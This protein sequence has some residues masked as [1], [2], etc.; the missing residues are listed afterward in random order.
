MEC[1][2]VIQEHENLLYNGFETI[3]SP[4]KLPITN[5]VTI[6]AG[7]SHSLALSSDGKLYGWGSNLRNQITL[8]YSFSLSPTLIK[9]PYTIKK[10]YAGDDYSFALTNEGQGVLL[11]FYRSFKV[12][13]NLNNIVTLLTCG[14][15][16]VAVEYI[17]KNEG[18]CL[19]FFYFD[20]SVKSSDWDD[21]NNYSQQLSNSLVEI[22]VSKHVVFRNSSI[23]LSKS[24]IFLDKH[25]LFVINAKGE[26]LEFDK[27]DDD[28]PFNNKP[29]KVP[30]LNNMVSI[31]GY[32]GIY[33]AID[34][35]G[36]VFVWGDLS[37]I[38]D[39]YD[40][41]NKEPICVEALN[42]LQGI[43]VGHDFLFAYNKNTV[44]AWGRNDKGQLGT[45]DLIDRPQPVKVFELRSPQCF[46][47]QNQPVDRMFSGYCSFVKARF[48]TKCSISKRVAKL[49]E[50][51]LDDHPIQ[52]KV[53]SNSPQDLN[54]NENIIE[55]HLRLFTPDNLPKLI[56]TR[57]KKLD[58][59]YDNVEYNP[60]L[61]SFFPNVEFVKLAG[62]SGLE[63]LPLNLTHLANLKCLELDYLF[64]VEQLP[65][66]LVKLV[67]KYFDIDVV[68]L[69]HLCSLKEL[70][71]LSHAYTYVPISDSLLDG[72]VPLP[73]SIVRFEVRLGEPVNVEIQL[74]NLK[75][76]IINDHVP[77]NI[78]KQ[79]F[80]SL[81][82]I[83]LITPVQDGLLDS[84]LSPTKLID[85]GSIGSVKLIKN[86]Y[87][88][89]LSCF[90]WWIQYPAQRYL[91]DIFGDYEGEFIL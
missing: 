28:V 9:I 88:V 23:I 51:V 26:V 75:E 72:E 5:I 35:N 49:I 89:E 71:V 10:L 45:G 14:D 56:Y 39:V 30:G 48:C 55:L 3:N 8:S 32:D 31:S 66:S 57:I 58:V 70:V 12:F 63:I 80:P 33:A 91:I 21:S 6:S 90:P 50:K 41:T 86:E 61:L 2:D 24:F 15:C 36:K 81:E 62:V 74:P 79:N 27:G 19:R 20:A 64:K 7:Y 47:S 87:L 69:S 16:F 52:N 38:S 4:I 65:T 29:T 42:N 22:P 78:T 76:L 34:N 82:F 53:S 18:Q 77:S 84:P 11:G 54:I 17:K 37:R 46:H 83:Q 13:E 1:I 67:L 68:D 59:Y 40:D 60:Q 85:H 43:S 25:R 73:Q 44:W